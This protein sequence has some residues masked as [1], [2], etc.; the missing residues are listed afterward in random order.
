[1]YCKLFYLKGL[2][3][4]YWGSMGYGLLATKWKSPGL[5][6]PGLF[7][8]CFNYSGLGKTLLQSVFG[9]FSVG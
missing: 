1:M 4:K 5:W 2:A 8:S 6:A 3:A 9:L 7:F